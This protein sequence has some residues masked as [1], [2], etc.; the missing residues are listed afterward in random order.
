MNKH[1]KYSVASDLTSGSTGLWEAAENDHFSSLSP[2]PLQSKLFHICSIKNNYCARNHSRNM[3][4]VHLQSLGTSDRSSNTFFSV[5]MSLYRRINLP[6]VCQVKAY[7]D[8]QNVILQQVK[9][10]SPATAEDNQHLTHFLSI[11]QDNCNISFYFAR[12]P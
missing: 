1:F 4:V 7:T 12:K 9:L 2:L 3:K 6:S 10:F 8:I 5:P 11:C